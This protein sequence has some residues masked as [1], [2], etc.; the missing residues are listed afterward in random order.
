I[1]AL[2]PVERG[3]SGHLVRLKIVGGEA[4]CTVGKELEIRRVLSRSHLKSAAITVDYEYAGE[5]SDGVPRV[6][7]RF[8]IH[9]AGWGHGVGLCQIGAAVMAAEGRAYDEILRH[10]YEGADIRR[11]YE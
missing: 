10:Y 7:Q 11:L 5:A 4:S 9:G 6:P 8:V 3:R 2:E 1:V